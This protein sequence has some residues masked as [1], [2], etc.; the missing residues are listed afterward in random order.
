[1]PRPSAGL[2]TPSTTGR[3]TEARPSQPTRAG[4]RQRLSG[5]RIALGEAHS[6]WACN[7]GRLARSSGQDSDINLFIKAERRIDNHET[8]ILDWDNGGSW[9]GYRLCPFQGDRLA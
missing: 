5:A 1:M 3:T 4:L 9:R 7:P 6:G 2:C 8:R